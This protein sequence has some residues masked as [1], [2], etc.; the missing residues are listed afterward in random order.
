MQFNVV[1]IDRGEKRSE[2]VSFPSIEQALSHYQQQGLVVEDI[3]SLPPTEGTEEAA[4]P[5]AGS[6]P[7]GGALDAPRRQS[8][9]PLRVIL[10]KAVCFVL[11]FAALAVV[12]V[13]MVGAVAG[14]NA[15]LLFSCPLIYSAV[16]LVPSVW[17]RGFTLWPRLAGLATAIVVSLLFGVAV[18]LGLALRGQDLLELPVAVLQILWVACGLVVLVGATWLS[19]LVMDRLRG[20]REEQAAWSAETARR[21][22]AVMRLC[23]ILMVAGLAVG[24]LNYTINYQ[25]LVGRMGASM[26]VVNIW[27]FL[28]LSL[29]YSLFLMIRLYRGDNLFRLVYGVSFLIGTPLSIYGLYTNFSGNYSELLFQAGAMG[30]NAVVVYLI[31]T[32][33]ARSWFRDAAA[34][35]I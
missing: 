24:L 6:V 3:A 4:A 19:V 9:K 22:P 17:R 5:A 15:F 2:I 10:L 14:P 31:L 21:R 34:R 30:L 29:I 1:V 20:R 16:A 8:E 23:L 28:L 26:P 32:E 35:R 33:P 13:T 25:A 11:L 18:P 7:G 12:Q 27:S